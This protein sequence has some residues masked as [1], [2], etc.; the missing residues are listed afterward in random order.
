MP[1]IQ[2]PVL[3]TTSEVAE[4][5]RVH[6]TTLRRWVDDGTIAAVTLPG[7]RSLRFRRD[8]ILAI[9]NGE[10]SGAAS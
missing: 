5:L 2:L 3:M 8:D 10:H 1:E 4:Q 7:T 6:R 9:L